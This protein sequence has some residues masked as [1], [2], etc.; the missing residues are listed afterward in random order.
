MRSIA[1][2]LCCGL[3]LITASCGF[4]DIR[5]RSATLE[6]LLATNAPLSAVESAIGKI[7]IYRRGS[8][9]WNTRRAAC[10]R[11]PNSWYQQLVQKIDNASAFGAISTPSMQTW[12]FLDDK[13]RIIDFEVGTQ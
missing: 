3:L 2:C 11:L 1:T 10:A 4:N 9:E 6:K 12:V 7:P 8:P 5:D 13:D